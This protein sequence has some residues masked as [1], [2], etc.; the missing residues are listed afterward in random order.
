[1]SYAIVFEKNGQ[2]E[3]LSPGE[4]ADDDEIAYEI[5]AKTKLTLL[6][7]PQFAAWGFPE[8]Q[9]IVN[10]F[11]AKTGALEF[12][13]RVTDVQDTMDTSG[14]FCRR[15]TCACEMDYLDDTRVSSTQAA[16]KRASELA[17]ELIA[18]HNARLD[19]DAARQFSVGTIATAKTLGTALTFDYCTTLDALKKVFVDT[20]GME[21]RTRHVNGVNYF[22]AADSFG[23]VSDM[24]IKIGDNLKSVR[25]AYS[26]ADKLITRL[27]PL[28]GVGYNGKRLT[29]A[30]VNDDVIY[31]DNAEL[32]AQY[33]IHEGVLIVNELAPQYYG[34]INTLAQKLYD[35]GAEEAAAL[36]TPAVTISLSALDLK[37]LG[38]AGYSAF[39]VGN[40]YYVI[41]PKLGIFRNMRVTGLKRKLADE[42][43][44]SLT[45]AAG[46]KRR[47]IKVAPLSRQLANYSSYYNEYID[48]VDRKRAETEQKQ[49][50][51]NLDGLKLKKLT[52]EEYEELAE[53]GEL[54]DDTIYTV[55]GED[56]ETGEPTVEQYL[57][58][59]HISEGG[60][61]DEGIPYPAEMIYVL[62]TACFGFAADCSVQSASAG[63]VWVEGSWDRRNV[64]VSGETKQIVVPVSN[65]RVQRTT[66]YPDSSYLYF[67]I[68]SDESLSYTGYCV[69]SGGYYVGMISGYTKLWST[70]QIKASSRWVSIAGLPSG[71]AA[72]HLQA[73]KDYGTVV[74]ND[75]VY[76]L[77]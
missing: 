75:T 37:K 45:I 25:A 71:T 62:D 69:D 28:G 60:G 20:L 55:V 36:S 43:N 2:T 16:D 14:K 21:I 59:T 63:A 19:G 6:I 54:D 27:I 47:E 76:Y 3:G 53:E 40:T 39:A 44:V 7:Y 42:K 18:A 8:K 50:E 65:D 10:A 5:S 24:V 56:P 74:R 32:A 31:I 33:G 72:V 48:D 66:I 30:P 68:E 35:I 23:T 4:I 11:S 70:P 77:G 41:C 22:D 38:L 57:G 29:I 73:G 51:L 17:S 46:S 15:V 58:G 26:A 52:P 49:L 67:D 64:E 9:T 1:M 12:H 34:Q 61:G 13:G